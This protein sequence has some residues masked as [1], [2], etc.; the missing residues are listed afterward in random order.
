MKIF[1]GNRAQRGA[2]LLLFVL[3]VSMVILS[4]L[5]T[6]LLISTRIT[7]S[8]YDT[9]R[10]YESLYADLAA[11]KVS[12]LSMLDSNLDNDW[13]VP[14]LYDTFN[15]GQDNQYVERYVYKDGDDVVFNVLTNTHRSPRNL[16]LTYQA[17]TM[18][19]RPVDVI[20][21]LDR[22]DSM[23]INNLDGIGVSPGSPMETLIAASTDFV[24]QMQTSDQSRLAVYTYATKV[25]ALAGSDTFVSAPAYPSL[26]AQIENMHVEGRNTSWAG[27]TNLGGALNAAYRL[28]T[29]PAQAAADPGTQRYVILLSDG[30]PMVD[31]FGT[32]CFEIAEWERANGFPDEPLG[33]ECVYDARNYSVEQA[34]LIKNL[35]VSLFS[36][37]L[38]DSRL[39][40]ARMAE[41][42]SS[43]PYTGDKHLYLLHDPNDLSGLA[44]I[45]AEVQRVMVGMG[46]L[47]VKEIKPD[48]LGP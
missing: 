15:L 11:S 34:S 22:S 21:L 7:Q 18:S 39:D 38:G 6:Y 46:H 30:D 29:D 44:A 35:G 23:D 27:E 17:P 25:N 4:I 10:S 47:E 33:W 26:I 2:G 48:T 37:G 12:V 1:D 20:L 43:N 16:E 3:I 40:P 32:N 41:Y 5:I 36:V 28:L 19:S 42:A 14:G 8:V 31:R 9:T 24:R 13:E 45:Y